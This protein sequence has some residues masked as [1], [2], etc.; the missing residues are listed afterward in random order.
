MV[1]VTPASPTPSEDCHD[2]DVTSRMD[3]SG[4]APDQEMGFV[5]NAR[6]FLASPWTGIALVLAMIG[7]LRL[8]SPWSEWLG[9]LRDADPW[10]LLAAALLSLPMI[11]LRMFRMERLLHELRAHRGPH[12]RLTSAMTAVGQ[13]PVGTVGGDAYRI[14]KY[15]CLGVDPERGTAA[16]AILRV[17][18]FASTLMIAGALGAWFM[19]SLLP[20]LALAL[21]VALV[22][23]LATS[24]HP[25]KAV[26]RLTLD[27][28]SSSPPGTKPWTKALNAL[29]RI[30]GRTLDQA[31]SLH[32]R[33]LA[34]VVALSFALTLTKG[35]M[36]LL[37]ARA[38]GLDV[39]ILGAAF[40]LVAG[41]I[42]CVIPSPAG[43][44]GLREGGIVGAFAILGI[45]STP[46]TVASLLFRAALIAG[47]LLAWGLSAMFAKSPD[48]VMEAA[49]A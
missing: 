39:G 48:A 18:G 34:L 29:R 25:P 4:E 6:A 10:L 14:V 15:S 5:A 13:L 49:S 30:L 36:I 21:G 42:M 16:T 43:T 47:A 8:I 28:D 23:V 46:A 2:I 37:C 19:D 40:A 12:A 44:V 41:N 1:T 7:A 20:L 31:R 17:A 32:R 22:F 26:S 3:H 45:A 9:Y 35:A 33:D 38:L 27:P 11:A 24:G